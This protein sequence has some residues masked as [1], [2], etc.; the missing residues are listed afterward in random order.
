MRF[1]EA[2]NYYRTHYCFECPA[3]DD[4]VMCPVNI[5]RKV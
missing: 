3:F 1:K 5:K 2:L 4:K